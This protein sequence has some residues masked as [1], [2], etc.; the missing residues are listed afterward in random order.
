MCVG[1]GGIRLVKRVRK[2]AEI[3]LKGQEKQCTYREKRIYCVYFHL[4][5]LSGT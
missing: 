4:V 3:C 2:E 5:A 1:G